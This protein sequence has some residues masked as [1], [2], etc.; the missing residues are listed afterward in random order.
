M[1]ARIERPGFRSTLAGEVG[2]FTTGLGVAVATFFGLALGLGVATAG[3][4]DRRAGDRSGRD[5][6]ATAYRFGGLTTGSPGGIGAGLGRLPG[7]VSADFATFRLTGGV[8]ATRTDPILGGNRR[9]GVTLGFG[10]IGTGTCLAGV[11]AVPPLAG[12][13]FG[14]AQ[15]RRG[16]TVGCACA[17]ARGRREGLSRLTVRVGAS[18]SGDW[19]ATDGDLRSEAFVGV[20]RPVASRRT[21]ALFSAARD[22]FGRGSVLMGAPATRSS[23]TGVVRPGERGAGLEA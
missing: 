21:G 19:A 15:T 22:D 3:D 11:G 4:A 18:R 14:V 7:T 20:S 17:S 16:S 1:G 8:E 13:W 5:F 23:L 9:S 10:V 12:L 6:A 2:S